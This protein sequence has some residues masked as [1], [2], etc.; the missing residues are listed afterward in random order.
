MFLLERTGQRDDPSAPVG[1][2]GPGATYATGSELSSSAAIA[3]RSASSRSYAV[4][5][6]R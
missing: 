2:D 1:G 4:I 6:R 5:S 3:A